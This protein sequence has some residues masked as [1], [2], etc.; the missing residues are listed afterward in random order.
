MCGIC[1]FINKHTTD[2][3]KFAVQYTQVTDIQSEK[4]VKHHIH[5]SQLQNTEKIQFSKSSFSLRSLLRT[6][7]E[8]QH[9][10]TEHSTHTQL[11]EG[12]AA[13]A[14]I[15]EKESMKN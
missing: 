13:T 1:K 5:D 3:H 9:Q 8:P 11:S 10:I 2:D 4:A 14:E 12:R 6:S 15:R 7:A